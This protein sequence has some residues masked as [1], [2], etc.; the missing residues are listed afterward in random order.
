[1]KRSDISLLYLT[2][3]YKYKL[4]RIFVCQL[5]IELNEDVQSDCNLVLLK[6]NGLLFV[7]PGFPWDGASG[8]T[9]DTKSSMRGAFIHDVIYLLLRQKKLDSKLR[10]LADQILRD[11]CILDKMFRCRASKW[12]KAVRKY[13]LNAASIR[14]KVYKY[15]E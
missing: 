14:R 9:I 13:G 10:L 15:G 5:P 11:V 6:K 1:M 4:E 8:I 3:G 2:K 7:K 12:F